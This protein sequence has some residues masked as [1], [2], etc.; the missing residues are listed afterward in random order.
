MLGINLGAGNT[1]V[2]ERQ[3]QELLAF[4]NLHPCD[5]GWED[6]C[7]SSVQLFIEH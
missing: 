7:F 5:G 3:R 4:W 6:L 1:V 2:K